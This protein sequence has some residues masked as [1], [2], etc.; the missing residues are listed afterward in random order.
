MNKFIITSIFIALIF[1]GSYSLFAQQQQILMEE[2][3][4]SYKTI[5][6]TLSQGSNEGISLEAAKII[7]TTI[8]LKSNVPEEKAEQFNMLINRIESHTQ[9][10]LDEKEI[11]LLRDRYDLLSHD[12][13]G[14]LNTFGSNKEY[15]VYACTGDLMYWVQQEKE[16]N[17]PYCDIPCGK[18]ISVIK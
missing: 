4:D 14:Y 17:D 8:K 15:Y 18:I 9:L 3:L 16:Q 10:L 13:L 6:K 11:K 7:S 12:I 2:M 1:L 5:G